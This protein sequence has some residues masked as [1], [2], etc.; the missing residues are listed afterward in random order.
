MLAFIDLAGLLTPEHLIALVTLTALE[1]VLGI[2]NIVFIAILCARLPAEQQPRARRVGLIGAL[3]MRVAFL[4]CLSWIARL[5]TPI[6]TFTALGNE[7][8]LS[9]RDVILLVGGLVLLAK[10][11]KE[12]HHSV[13]GGE[14]AL[15]AGKGRS[16][17]IIVGQ[18]MLMD[19]VFSIDSVITAI[20]MAE[21][22]EVMVLAVVLSMVV[23]LMFAGRISD[24]VHRHPTV[25]MLALSFLLLIG[26]SLVAEGLHFHVPKGYIYFAM[27][28][29]LG[30]EVLNIRSKVKAARLK[31]AAD[32]ASLSN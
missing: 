21:A 13:E 8:A 22:I 6:V 3:L 17:G 10:S 24:F 29:S 7:F 14:H 12:I 32:G 28:F 1:I 26:M 2:D 16:F 30:V 19:I 20:G 23:M 4:M 25:K 27:A 11:T 9:W 18:I 15:T 31:A 5:T